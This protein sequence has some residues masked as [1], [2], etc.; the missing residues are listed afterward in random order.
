MFYNLASEVISCHFH[1][2]LLVTQVTPILCGKSIHEGMN[3]GRE[4]PWGTPWSLV[5]LGKYDCPH[6]T[7]Q[8]TEAQKGKPGFPKTHSRCVAELGL[9]SWSPRVQHHAEAMLKPER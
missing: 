7:A 4:D 9:E 8:K 5:T 1:D 3:T 2:T 6:F